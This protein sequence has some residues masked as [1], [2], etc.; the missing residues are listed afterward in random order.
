[1]NI[2]ELKIV[3]KFSYSQK[4]EVE[5]FNKK[6][7]GLWTLDDDLRGFTMKGDDVDFIE[8]S[9]RVEKELCKKDTFFCISELS[10][11]EFVCTQ[12]GK[13]NQDAH[14]KMDMGLLGNEK[15]AVKFNY[16]ATKVVQQRKVKKNS[17]MT[18]G[19]DSICKH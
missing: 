19:V 5:Y 10:G 18:G 9:R 16:P 6:G 7:D 2:S 17:S 15:V 11:Y 13:H 14:F 4:F 12:T 8:A 1:M 3:N